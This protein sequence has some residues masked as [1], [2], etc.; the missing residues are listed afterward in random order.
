[1]NRTLLS[2]GWKVVW[3]AGFMILA[4]FAF[5]LEKQV[6]E[7][8]SST[9]EMAPLFWFYSIVPLMFGIYASLVLVKKWSVHVNWPLLLC[10]A[11]PC[12]LLACSN[13]ILYFF[14]SFEIPVYLHVPH[15][16]LLN[17]ISN[18]FGMVAGISLVLSLFNDTKK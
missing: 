5:H 9:F 3:L 17:S 14:S 10:V 2:Y 7:A 8:T 13:L 4:N 1:M 16:L 11:L 12:L 15:W 18:L 6:Q